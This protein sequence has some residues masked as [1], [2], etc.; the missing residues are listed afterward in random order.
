[1]I[2]PAHEYYFNFEKY[3][4]QIALIDGDSGLEFSYLDCLNLQKQVEPKFSNKR[5][6]IFLFCTNS[7][8]DLLCYMTLL[9]LEQTICLLDDRLEFSV[10]QQLIALYSPHYIMS[11]SS[12]ILEGY[13]RVEF[14][15]HNLNVYELINSKKGP[16]LHPD[17]RLLLSS[18]GS[19]GTPKIIRLS[20]KNL[21]S[22]TLSIVKHLEITPQHR[23]IIHLPMQFAFCLCFIDPHLNQGASLVL[24]K[25]S[26]IEPAFWKIMQSYQCTSFA[27]VPLT[28]QILDKIN[29][30]KIDLPFLKIMIQGAGRLNRSLALKFYETMNRRGGRFYLTYGQTETG[31]ISYV[32]HHLLEQVQEGAVGLSIPPSKLSVVNDELVFES[33]SVMMGYAEKAEDLA[34]DDEL[35]GYL[36]TG[37]LGFEDVNKIFYIKG[38]TKRIAK[39]YGVRISLDEL[40][41]KI[42][43]LCES[44]ITSNDQ[45]FF[46]HL[47]K[48]DAQYFSECVSILSKYQ[49]L[50]SSLFECRAIENF[51]RT[52][53]G[54]ID[55]KALSKT[56]NP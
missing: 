34:K 56:K 43:H 32:P 37:D 1:M 30:D 5:R 27:G 55:Y 53:T 39:I 2:L 15:I 8:E 16:S 51:P 48:S 36:K 28:Y 19:T 12:N 50:H 11:K 46:I 9:N 4:N 7:I 26:V 29:F 54:K 20:K 18:S 13:E 49:N 21:I 45:K 22:N 31:R 52:V 25:K 44:V 3:G 14:P 40:E 10:K 17:L 47:Q 41:K 42:D 24:T 33:K 38:R 6:L 23:A 35:N